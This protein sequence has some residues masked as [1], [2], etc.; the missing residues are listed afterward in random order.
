MAADELAKHKAT[1]AT[2]LQAKEQEVATAKDM[3]AK[4]KQRLE[5]EMEQQKAAA[6]AS[7]A[8]LLERMEGEMAKQKAEAETHLSKTVR[9]WQQKVLCCLVVMTMS[10]PTQV[11]CLQCA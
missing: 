7:E 9:E 2:Q 8:A 6:A 4:Q 11:Y 3:A 5:S 10:E 1:A